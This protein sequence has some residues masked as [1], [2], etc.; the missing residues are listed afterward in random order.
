VQYLNIFRI[1]ALLKECLRHHL[2]RL[3]LW[4][5]CPTAL[6]FFIEAS[7]FSELSEAVR[8]DNDFFI[9]VENRPILVSDTFDVDIID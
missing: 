3:K 8:R 6:L 4:T 2:I 5:E 1:D 7:L 9:A